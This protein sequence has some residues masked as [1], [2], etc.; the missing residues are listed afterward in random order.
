VQGMGFALI[1]E[2]VWD[3]A[4]LANP[5]LMDYKIPT[6]AEAPEELHAYLIESNDPSGPFG[7]K[8]VGELGINGVAAAI[9]NGIADATGIRLRRL[10]LTGERVLNGLLAVR[11]E[12]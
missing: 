3:G 12:P 11:A 10:P 8:S 1:E 6:F 7:A 5:S 9:A 4:R 2:M